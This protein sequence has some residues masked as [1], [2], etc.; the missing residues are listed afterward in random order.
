MSNSLNESE[1]L[2]AAAK[3]RRLTHCIL[4]VGEP[5]ET[6]ALACDLAA[7]LL[8]P[9]GGE[10]GC[11]CPVCRRVREGIH[12]DVE[13]LDKGES[14]IGVE[15]VRA[16]RASAFVA[17]LEAQGKVY[18]L[19]HVQNMNAAAQNAA[20]KLFEEPPQGVTFFLLCEN[21]AAML[22]TVRSRCMTV[23]LGE[24]RSEGETNDA[25]EAARAQAKEFAEALLKDDEL[26]LY[27]AC[28]KLEKLKR[29]EAAAFFDETLLLVRGALRAA[30]H[31]DEAADKN[32]QALSLLGTVKLARI[33]EIL[34]AR[35]ADTDRNVGVAH[36][37]GTISA[38]YFL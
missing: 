36:L 21:H 31:A 37:M 19:K 15:D 34:L 30:L 38:E 5:G 24:G 33:A 7:A 2:R 12:P 26:T 17:P 22:E 13:T 35:R 8:C 10:A 32:V 16:L 28:M 9:S 25:R 29:A 3:S 4:L 1:F 11:A 14:L 23:V 18:I 6:G 27:L 20:L